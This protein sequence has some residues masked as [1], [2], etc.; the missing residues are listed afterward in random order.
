VK[1]L[2]K[3]NAV[4][5][6]LDASDGTHVQAYGDEQPPKELAKIHPSCPLKKQKLMTPYGIAQTFRSI[7]TLEEDVPFTFILHKG[8]LVATLISPTSHWENRHLF[9]A[10]HQQCGHIGRLIRCTIWTRRR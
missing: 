7:G 6:M 10:I 3:T 5:G 2:A 8:I 9:I 4:L 1:N